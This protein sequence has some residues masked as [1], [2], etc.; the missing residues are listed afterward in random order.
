MPTAT[1]TI[2][3]AEAAELTRQA[4]YYDEAALRELVAAAAERQAGP[5]RAWLEQAGHGA[6]SSPAERVAQQDLALAALR[7]RC[8]VYEVAPGIGSGRPAPFELR[9]KRNAVFHLGKTLRTAA[10]DGL[11][12]F[13]AC[14]TPASLPAL[15]AA[16]GL[17]SLGHLI[18]TLVDCY[19]KIEEPQEQAVF[20]AVYRLQNQLAVTDYQAL[21]GQDYERAY[22]RVS[23]T[24]AEVA[25]EVAGQVEE[26][27]LDMV[28][29]GMKRRGVLGER[30]GRWF[31]PFW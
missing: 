3:P 19:E 11:G 25:R 14:L 9:V 21:A 28:L 29:H 8:E 10:V 1:R 16:W 30:R 6:A 18:H 7:E 15:F 31:V 22:V 12:L 4:D 23:P 20:E 26:G 13:L 24:R 5:F 2:T 27:H 17:G